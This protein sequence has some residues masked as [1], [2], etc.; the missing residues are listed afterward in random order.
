M[1]KLKNVLKFG[2]DI[3]FGKGKIVLNQKFGVN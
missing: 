2:A 1:T 3:E